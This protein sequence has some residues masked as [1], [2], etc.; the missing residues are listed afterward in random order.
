[1][2]E[3]EYHIAI[4]RKIPGEGRAT[5]EWGGYAL[6]H[7]LLTAMMEKAAQSGWLFEWPEL[8]SPALMARAQVQ[9][10]ARGELE[11]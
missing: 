3:S 4:T 7:E 6:L 9:A 5:I 2:A 8:P 10:K 11:P 1:V